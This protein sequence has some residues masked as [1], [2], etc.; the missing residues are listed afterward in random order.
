MLAGLLDKFGTLVALHRRTPGLGSVSGS[1]IAE[2]QRATT[3]P[4]DT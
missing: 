3:E 4:Y 1:W 2:Y